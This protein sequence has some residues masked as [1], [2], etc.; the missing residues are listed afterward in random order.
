MTHFFIILKN[1]LFV[2]GWCRLHIDDISPKWVFIG[3]FKNIDTL[4]RDFFIF[5]QKIY[6]KSISGDA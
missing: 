6:H 1:D 2:K 3:Y 5:L 4:V